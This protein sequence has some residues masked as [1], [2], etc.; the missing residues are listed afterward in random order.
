MNHNFIFQLFNSSNL[1]KFF[2][3]ME[4]IKQFQ[5]LSFFASMECFIDL[6][7]CLI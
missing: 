2:A 7:N 6:I 1:K 3:S 5:F 4:D